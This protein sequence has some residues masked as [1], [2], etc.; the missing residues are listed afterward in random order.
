[1]LIYYTQ[2]GLSIAPPEKKI[3]ENDLNKQKCHNNIS[4]ST[5]S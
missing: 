1:M 4:L 2:I 5:L 3:N